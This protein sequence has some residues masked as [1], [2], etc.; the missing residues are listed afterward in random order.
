MN[1]DVSKA[2]LSK[3]QLETWLPIDTAPRDGTSVRVLPYAGYTH[4]FW[5]DGF[6]WWHCVHGGQDGDYASGP[7]PRSWTPVPIE[8]EFD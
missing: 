6:W 3:D 5:Q 4:A 8:T 1:D 2:M 7:E